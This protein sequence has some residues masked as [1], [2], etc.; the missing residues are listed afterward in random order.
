MKRKT[1]TEI[2]TEIM[3][4]SMYGA[5]SQMFVIDALSKFADTVA[6]SKPKDYPKNSFINGEAWIGV[7]KE[8]KSKLERAYK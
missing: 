8:I 5:L 1:N 6:K 7:A 3:E 2:V 4:Y